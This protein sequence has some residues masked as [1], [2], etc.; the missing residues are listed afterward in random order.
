MQQSELDNYAIAHTE[1]DSDIL[2]EL[3]AYT[4]ANTRVPQ[5]L[6]GPLVTRTLQFLIKLMQAQRVLEIGC[7]TGY[8]ALAMAEALP[9]GGELITLEIDPKNAEIAR[10]FLEKSAHGPKVKI[11]EGDAHASL[12]ALDG[13]LDFVFIDADKQGYGDYI[14]AVY[15]LLR[16]GGVIALDNM[17]REG[18]VLAPQHETAKYIDALNKRLLQD[19]RFTTLLLPVRDGVTLLYK[20]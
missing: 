6:S 2:K 14:E 19:E 8:S 17:L 18:Q 3:T 10:S 1:A 11:V 7:F 9:D 4:Q 20:L 5:M 13:P 15:P 16:P 12:Q